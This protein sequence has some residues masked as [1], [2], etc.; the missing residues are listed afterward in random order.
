M[1]PIERKKIQTKEKKK[2]KRYRKIQE[3]LS[4]GLTEQELAKQ[5]DIKVASVK[6]IMLR[7][8]KKD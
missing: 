1:T 4:L 3:Y 6:R 5:L 2:N 8:R 7:A